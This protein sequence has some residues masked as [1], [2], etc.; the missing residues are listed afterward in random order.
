M[1]YNCLSNY[2]ILWLKQQDRLNL[3]C[4]VQTLAQIGLETILRI[5]IDVIKLIKLGRRMRLRLRKTKKS[6]HIE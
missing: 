3:K 5:T 2:A 4:R 6:E 1:R